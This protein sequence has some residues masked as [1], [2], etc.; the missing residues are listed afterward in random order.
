MHPPHRDAM[1]GDR[2]AI[3]LIC[4]ADGPEAAAVYAHW[5]GRRPRFDM[6]VIA[7]GKDTG[8][9]PIRAAAQAAPRYA[10]FAHGTTARHLPALALPGSTPPPLRAFLAPVSAPDGG[11]AS[12]GAA[13]VPLTLFASAAPP[14]D[15]HRVMADGMAWRDRWAG[16]FDMRLFDAGPNFLTRCTTEVLF[17]IEQELS[18]MPS[19]LPAVPA[20][21]EGARS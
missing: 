8:D 3:T 18:A 21:A 11:S 12:P 1:V 13:S 7:C 9:G 5:A 17:L 4:L 2:P 19:A 6:T 15:R 16:D 14:A 10:V 20:I